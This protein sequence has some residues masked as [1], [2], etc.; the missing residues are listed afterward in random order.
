MRLLL[1]FFLIISTMAVHA[2]DD[3]WTSYMMPSENHKILE[4]LSGEWMTNGSFW[5]TGTGEPLLFT[6]DCTIEMALSG[7]FMKMTQTGVMSDQP[8]E[9]VSYLGYDNAADKFTL[10]VLNSLGTGTLTLSGTWVILKREINLTGELVNPMTKK[11]VLIRQVIRL[12]DNN[13]FTIEN[14]D[15]D[16]D[17][18]EV[19][20]VLY[21]FKRKS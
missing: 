5:T 21:Q 6:L 3:A 14:Y 13:S 11:P 12:A 9:S 1:T 10:T 8:F 20:T 16:A 19:R 7:R 4:K 15:I 18:K 2:Q 17:G